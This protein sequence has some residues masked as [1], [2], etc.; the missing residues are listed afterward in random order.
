MGLLNWHVRL[1]SNRGI[2]IVGSK[3]NFKWDQ[4]CQLNFLMHNNCSEYLIAV[5]RLHTNALSTTTAKLHQAT[6]RS[7][8]IMYTIQ[9][10][11]HTNPMRIIL[12]SLTRLNNLNYQTYPRMI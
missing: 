4:I 2:Y 12:S 3:F 9:C 8:T 11:E 5:N 6:N 10:I 1:R 7:D